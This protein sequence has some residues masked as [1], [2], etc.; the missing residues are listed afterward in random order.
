MAPKAPKED[1]GR[2]A[3]RLDPPLDALVEKIAAEEP[4]EDVVR[5]SMERTRQAIPTPGNRLSPR[6]YRRLAT[7]VALATA[8]GLVCVLLAWR[9]T[10]ND[11]KQVEI[12]AEQ[13]PIET[14]RVEIGPVEMGPSERT[15]PNESE[16]EEKLAVPT[17][18]FWAYHRAARRSP[19]ALESLLNEHAEQYAFGRSASTGLGISTKLN[20]ETL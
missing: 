7:A 17:P 18:T 3:N 6:P 16:V 19:E 1:R 9:F 4:P 2:P 12:V 14:G 8:A 13:G 11:G 15:P 10:G 20:E 5:R